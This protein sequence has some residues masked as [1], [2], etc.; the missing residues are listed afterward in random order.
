MKIVYKKQ[1]LLWAILFAASFVFGQNRGQQK[2]AQLPFKSSKTNFSQKNLK[3]YGFRL[4]LDWYQYAGHHAGEKA[5]NAF[6]YR[7]DTAVVYSNYVNPQ[8][9][10]YFY[11]STGNKSV[12]LLQQLVNEKW[13]YL[14]KDSAVYD[15]VGNQLLLLSQAWDNNTWVNASRTLRHFAINHNVVD[16]VNE[17]WQNDK[18]VPSDSTHYIYDANGNQLTAYNAGWIDSTASWE[19]KTFQISAYDSLGNLK[20]AL[21]EVW[22]DT[23]WLDSQQI[24]YDYDSAFNLTQGLIQHYG[25][26]NW[27]DSYRETYKY[28]SA[29]NRTSYTGQFWK[30][31]LWVNDQHYKYIYNV[32]SRLETA[33]GENWADSAWANYEKG[34]YT[35]NTYG[36]TETFLYQ[37]W[38]SDSAWGNVSLSQY[39]YDSAG[40]AYLANFFSWDTTGNSWQQN[41]D[42]LLQI[43]YNYGTASAFYTGYQVKVAYNE[44]LSTG[45]RKQPEKLISRFGCMPNPA[46]NQTTLVLGLKVKGAIMVSLYNL[47]GKREAIIFR[48]VM[49]K[50]PHRFP[51]SIAQFP[52]GL[53]FVSVSTGTQIKTIKLI[54][55][56]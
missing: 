36:G 8:R 46:V 19:S 37:Q 51:V 39:N 9:H 48:G 21:Y 27:V 49:D 56:K 54:I 24:L 32:Y 13:E 20:L 17:N 42:G 33:I 52:A 26:T 29:R 55:R 30:D 53:Y 10:I 11:D 23:V 12:S 35:Y 16:Q 7:I 45:I 50:G 2:N 5:K 41:Q 43:F 6:Q 14:S 4:G 25:D 40:N 1:V 38:V 44:P 18:W 47:I 22:H 28:D 3:K 31:S 15:S 34:Q